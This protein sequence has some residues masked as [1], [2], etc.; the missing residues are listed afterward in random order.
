GFKDVQPKADLQAWLDKTRPQFS[1]TTFAKGEYDRALAIFRDGKYIVS[2]NMI[3]GGISQ[4]DN[5][6]YYPLPFAPGIVSGVSD[7]GGGHPQLTPKFTM[8]DG[9]QLI[10][11]AWM[12]D[13]QTS[14]DGQRYVV[15]YHMDEL[16][17]LGKK[18]TVKDNRIKLQTTYTLEHGQLT[19]TDVY[20]PS[21]AQD[22]DKVT[23]EFASFSDQAT[24]RD[25][26]VT[27]AQG[28]VN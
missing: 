8:A 3:N 15:K 2:L 14:K 25:G 19:R 17:R 10:A 6:P 1:T 22:V 23:L 16:D 24:M 12:K 28:D 20:T 5:S 9:S 4:H 11:A 27:F 21:G 18:G 13:I 26:T 7:S